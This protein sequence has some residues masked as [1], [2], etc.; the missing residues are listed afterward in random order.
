MSTFAAPWRL[1][2]DVGY[3]EISGRAAASYR[4]APE[5]QNAGLQRRH[6]SG[7]R[8]LR[9]REGPRN[10][11]G[12]IVLLFPTTELLDRAN[13]GLKEQSYW[14]MAVAHKSVQ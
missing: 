6:A 7:K 1:F 10:H 8:S 13:N 9:L 2:P 3:P 4:S 11:H 5:Q 14:K 12:D